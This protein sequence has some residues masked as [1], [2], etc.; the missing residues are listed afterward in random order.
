MDEELTP[1]ELEQIRRRR[2]VRSAIVI[3][4]VVA[5]VATLLFPVII[6][7]VQTPREPDTVIAMQ[8]EV[9]CRTMDT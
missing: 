7:F 3:A 4:I 9:P 5:M 2:L 8:V 1:E 6:R